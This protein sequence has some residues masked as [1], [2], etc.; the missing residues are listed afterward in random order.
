VF[1]VIGNREYLQTGDGRTLKP[2]EKARQVI[3]A[4]L[5]TAGWVIQDYQ[6]LNLGAALGVAVREFPLG[7]DSADYLLFVER[8]A[9][10]VVEAKPVGTTLGGVSVQSDKYMKGIPDHVA[11]IQKPLPISYETTGVETYFRDI[12]DPNSRSRRVFSFH[13][14][15]TILDWV[16]EDR[17]LRGRLRDLPPLIEEGLRKCQIEA[18]D[19]LERSFAE[20]RSRALIQMA[21]GSGKTYAAVTS[22]Y[23]LIKFGKAK[24]ILFLVDRNNLGRQAY[25][26]FQQYKTP[27]DGRKFTE[28]Y[29]VQ[30]LTSNTIDKV[31]RVCISTIQRIFSMLKDGDLD[32]E[33]EERSGF[34]LALADDRPR[35]VR[36]NHKVPI[37]K[38]DFII[39]DECHRSIYNLWR[40]VLEYFDAFIVGLTAT[41]SMQTLG[42]FNQNL[43]TEYPHERAVADGVNVDYDIYRIRTKI[44]EKG[45]RVEAGLYVDK[46]DKLTRKKRW[47]VLDDDLEYEA[48]QLNHDIVAPDQI[49]TIIRVFKEKLFTEIFPGRKNVPKTIIFAKDDSHAEDIL[50]IVRE[51]FGKGNKFCKKITYKTTGEDTEHLIASFRNSY[52]PRIVVSVDMISTGTD[53]RP[54]ECLLFMRDVKSRVYFEQMKGRG[55]RVI[56]PTEMKSVT[57]DT[58][59]KTHYVIVDAVGVTEHDKTDSRPLERKPYVSFEKL[60]EHVSVGKRDKDTLSSLASRLSRLDSGLGPEEKK[61]IED[62]ADGMGFSQ[63]VNGLLDAIDP[64]IRRSRAAEMFDVDE[65]S[66]KQLDEATEALVKTACAPFD[67]PKLRQ[68]IIKVKKRNEQTIDTVSKDSVLYAGYDEAAVKRAKEIV[69]SF[70][71]FIDENKDELLAL[72][73]IYSTPYGQR[74]L[75]YEAI[76]ELAEVLQKP[77]YSLTSKLLWDAYERIEKSRV[78]GAGAR[79]LLT[80]I[81]SLIRYALG[82]S[83]VLAPFYEGVEERFNDWLAEQERRGREFTTEQIEWL[84]MIRDHIAQSL[85][86]EMDDFENVPF[87]HKGGI[88]RAHQIFGDDFQ[89]V[90]QVLN[91]ALV[92]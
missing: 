91:E 65:P 85:S 88:Y 21:T 75:T 45:S 47:E 22:C 44:T 87:Q 20:S 7:R 90:L 37:G 18:I 64:D 2:E 5:E 9:V 61:E 25:R 63:L 14:P 55:T 52:D 38:F 29:N 40:Q 59:C 70:K 71:Q 4:H 66:D 72:Q 33:N 24:R 49:R 62:A 16:I 13:K 50:H 43:V 68:I 41:P 28:L 12:R 79:K 31:S 81:I 60:L 82:K 54:V 17:T 56:S 58:S 76:K 53:I 77:P 23:R 46:R 36:Y 32:P 30:H 83:E 92:Q 11:C 51:E 10:G 6:E 27:D 48:K 42:F 3:D 15:E 1:S 84:E 19:G 67:N 78:H 39:T 8:K 34:E 74:N 80:D 89:Q 86:I 26:E 35:E 69:G 73:I 57:P